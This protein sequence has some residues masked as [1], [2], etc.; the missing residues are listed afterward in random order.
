MANSY[1]FLGVKSCGSIF[2]SA[3][4]TSVTTDAVVSTDSICWDVSEVSVSLYEIDP[5]SCGW[6]LPGNTLSVSIFGFEVSLA[7][8]FFGV[9]VG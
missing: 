8:F 6:E 4:K 5:R 1:C 3:W 9:A 7:V 2:S